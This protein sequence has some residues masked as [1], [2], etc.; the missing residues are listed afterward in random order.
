MLAATGS[1]TGLIGVA[2]RLITSSVGDT[3]LSRIRSLAQTL[4]RRAQPKHLVRGELG[5]Y[6]AA[7]HI[8]KQGYK[9]LVRRYRPK[10]R[11]G[12]IDIVARE[13]EVLVFVEV[14]TRSSED[15]GRPVDAVGPQKRRHLRRAALDY[16]R[17]L[18]SPRLCFR[19]DVVEVVL[20][21]DGKT[22]KEVRLLRN[23]FDL[24]E[25]YRY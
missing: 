8:R 3:I 10:S 19:F 21:A 7:A 9:I 20:N 12:D 25:V 2:A 1:I 15:F 24:G 18:G 23:V 22:A 13:G 4:R 5:E 6:L 16:L 11:R 14:K 17:R